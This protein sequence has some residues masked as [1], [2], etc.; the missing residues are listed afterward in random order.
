MSAD[1]QPGKYPFPQQMRLKSTAQFQTVYG[2]KKSISDSVLVVYA[3]PN[4]LPHSRI[5]LSVSRKVGGAV[6]RNRY[7]RLFREAFRFQQSSLPVGF[8]FVVIPRNRP[9]PP[10]LEEVSA[11]LT[12][13]A[14]QVVRRF[15]ELK[16][17][18][19]S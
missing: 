3:A 19:P 5:G 7:K 1:A 4:G 2:L 9:E 17:E 6:I 12:K 16:P 15:P 11:S 18:Q 14:G 13:L 8:D 10:T